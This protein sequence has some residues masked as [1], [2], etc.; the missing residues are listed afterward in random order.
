MKRST[1]F[2]AL[3]LTLCTSYSFATPTDNLN[4][5]IKTSF[6]HDFKN[7]QIMNTEVK[8]SFTK[9]T[10]KTNNVIMTAFYSEKGELM[11]VTR[12]IVSTQLPLNLLISL[13]NHYD[14]Y[15][16]SDLFEFKDDSQTSYYVTLE[17]SDTKTTLRSN[18]DG[19]EVY[20]STKK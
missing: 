15:W 10:F 12:N 2:F 4:W 14:G 11:A 7:A 6:Q 9:L 3:L 18:S 8:E 13:K 20:T 16:I 5:A 1:F 17:N 19:W